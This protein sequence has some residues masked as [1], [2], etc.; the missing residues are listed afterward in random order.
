[1]PKPKREDL[2]EQLAELLFTLDPESPG[3][4][5]KEFA[6][7][8][9]VISR[10]HRQ[11]AKKIFDWL[12]AQGWR[13]SYEDCPNDHSKLKEELKIVMSVVGLGD[14]G[15]VRTVCRHCGFEVTPADL[16]DD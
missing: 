2:V 6:A 15:V 11:I 14:I 8:S 9:Q 7:A 16:R 4:S 3:V 13:Q 1:M 5:W 10:R 12:E